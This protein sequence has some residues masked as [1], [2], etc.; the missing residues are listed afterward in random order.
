MS[1]HQKYRHRKRLQSVDRVIASVFDGLK[2]KTE[3]QSDA[4]HLIAKYAKLPTEAEMKPL[5]KYTVFDRFEKG[6]RKSV[7]RTPKWTKK[8][9]RVN[10]EYF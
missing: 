7:H 9:Q 5:D 1:S 2:G 3:Y 6:Y 10:P 8:T 4:K